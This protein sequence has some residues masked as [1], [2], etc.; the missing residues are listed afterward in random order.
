M[1]NYMNKWFT[2]ID[3]GSFNEYWNS[4]SHNVNL[5][6]IAMIVYVVKNSDGSDSSFVVTK[7]NLYDIDKYNNM[8]LV[9]KFYITIIHV[10]VWPFTDE[11]E[12]DEYC[13]IYGV[14]DF[15]YKLR[16]DSG[17]FEK[18]LGNYDYNSVPFSD[19]EYLRSNTFIDEGRINE[20]PIR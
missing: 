10:G 12:I 18:Y 20:L 19:E 1:Y 17:N 3:D 2:K 16:K 13:T 6:I 5:P 14:G 9:N 15:R 7:E 8:E 11:D 4:L